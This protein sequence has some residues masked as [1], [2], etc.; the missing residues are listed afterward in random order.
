M[1]EEEDGSAADAES[2]ERN[3]FDRDSDRSKESSLFFENLSSGDENDS[4]AC[5]KGN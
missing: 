1:L 3:P 5:E 4:Q 2:D